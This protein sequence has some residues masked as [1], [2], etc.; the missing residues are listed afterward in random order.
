MYYQLST[1]YAKL[2]PSFSLFGMQWIRP[3]PNCPNHS[4]IAIFQL[5]LA[6]QSLQNH[7]RLESGIN[8]AIVKLT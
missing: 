6:T 7:C 2:Q 1:A 8:D 3:S 4:S 5:D